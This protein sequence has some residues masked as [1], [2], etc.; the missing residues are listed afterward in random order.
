MTH[1]YT[2]SQWN[3]QSFWF[4]LRSNVS[5]SVQDYSD[6]FPLSSMGFRKHICIILSDTINTFN[7]KIRRE[8]LTSRIKTRNKIRTIF[9]IN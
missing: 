2:S 7:K 4:K 6:V 8:I 3:D 9:K 1:Q 5:F